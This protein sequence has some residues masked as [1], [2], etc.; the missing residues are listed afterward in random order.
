MKI[1]GN[2][3]WLIFGGFEIFLEY[4]VGGLILCLTIVGIPFGLQVFKLATLALWPFGKTIQ[5][6]QFAPGCL[7]TLMNLIW[8]IFGGILISLTHL[9]FGILLC[10][11]IVGIPWGRQHF[12]MTSLALSPFGKS[13]VSR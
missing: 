4:V 1:L 5:Y 12:K 2:L 8:L 13:L 11:T 6:K 9:F 3:V 7:S 10:F